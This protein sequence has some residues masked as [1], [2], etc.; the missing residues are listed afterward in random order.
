MDYQ[1]FIA[2][3]YELKRKCPADY[4]VYVTTPQEEPGAAPMQEL[5]GYSCRIIGRVEDPLETLYRA[6]IE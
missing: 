6:W 5:D 3:I 4:A 2:R 1:R